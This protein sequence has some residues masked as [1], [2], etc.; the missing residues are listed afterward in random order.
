MTAPVKY[1]EGAT[2]I[3]PK[4]I[5]V[6]EDRGRKDFSGLL[7]LRESIEQNGLLH[8]VAITPLNGDGT[9]ELV[10]GETRLRAMILL[11]IDEIPCSILEDLT[12]EDQRILELE[13]NVVRTDLA[14]QE[15]VELTRQID[16]ARKEKH[17]EKGRGD[18]GEGWTHEKTA[19]V[20]G[21]HPSTVS[22]DIKLATRLAENPELKELVKNL[23]KNVALQKIKQHDEVKRV[24]RLAEK[25][26]LKLSGKIYQGE[27]E[28]LIKSLGADTVDLVLTDPPFGVSM[29]EEMR[30][31]TGRKDDAAPVSYA[32]GLKESDNWTADKVKVLIDE[33]SGDLFRVLKPGGHLYMFFTFE[34]YEAWRSSLVNAGFVIGWV[35]VIWYK[36]RS[37]S[38][39]RGYD[40]M[41]C[42]EP[43]LFGYK[44][45]RTRRMNGDEKALIEVAPLHTSKK[46]H[47]FEKPTK[48][49]ERLIELSTNKGH[50]VLDPFCGS[51]ATLD[52]ARGIGRSY[53]GYELDKDHFHVA[54]GRLAE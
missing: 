44:P 35:P 13:E 27:A 36:G 17:G 40:F 19:E 9:Y 29:I 20:V 51:G 7:E 18:K 46:S 31:S 25:G 45:P 26:Q 34:V 5:S 23:P 43:I 24:E 49:L 37:V 32:A 39:G 52:A 33:I 54:Q 41:T 1:P 2:L 12:E 38:I 15:K 10:A 42:Y 8:P 53:I 6:R 22:K 28:V 50:V 48:L 30:N 4:A 14:W 47:P 11:G 16:I 21:S 3:N